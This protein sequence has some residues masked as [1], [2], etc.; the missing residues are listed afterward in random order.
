M[1]RDASKFKLANELVQNSKSE[2]QEDKENGPP[3][4]QARE[5]AEDKSNGPPARQ[6]IR[7]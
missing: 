7:Q 3:A 1:C 6:A 2:T 4:R 5:G